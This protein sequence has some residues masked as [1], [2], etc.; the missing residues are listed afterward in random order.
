[1]RQEGEKQTD[2]AS[3]LHRRCKCK[4]SDTIFEALEW[5][6][7]GEEGMRTRGKKEPVK[8]KVVSVQKATVRTVGVWSNRVSRR[9]S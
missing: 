7:S 1:M 2:G 6:G 3:A 5:V 9:S 4:G 8:I